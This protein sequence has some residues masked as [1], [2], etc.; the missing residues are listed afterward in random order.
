[1]EVLVRFVTT[2]SSKL[3]LAQVDSAAGAPSGP[4][5]SSDAVSLL[6]MW[7]GFF[8]LSKGKVQLFVG[9]KRENESLE[10]L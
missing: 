5:C 1:M 2:P 9:L 10:A 4:C 8:P 3:V 6:L 7:R